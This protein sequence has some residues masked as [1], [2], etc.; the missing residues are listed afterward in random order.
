MCQLTS[1]WETLHN[2]RTSRVITFYIL[3]LHNV[4]CQSGL[5]KAGGGVGWGGTQARLHPTSPA[6]LLLNKIQKSWL[7]T[8]V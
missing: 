7:G 3:N 2:A 8:S 1:F 5:S 4:I 6:K